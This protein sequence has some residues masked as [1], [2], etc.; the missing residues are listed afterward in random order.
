MKLFDKW[1][2]VIAL[3]LLVFVLVY[4]PS[5]S[6]SAIGLCRELTRKAGVADNFVEICNKAMPDPNRMDLTYLLLLA[7]VVSVILSVRLYVVSRKCGPDNT[8]K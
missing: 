3:L 2:F 1:S 8:P 7:C 5:A 4:L 6:I